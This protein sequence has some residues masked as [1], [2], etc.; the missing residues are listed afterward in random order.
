M[1]KPD[2][3]RKNYRLGNK[4]LKYFLDLEIVERPSFTLEKK[5]KAWYRL[6]HGLPPSTTVIR[7]KMVDDKAVEFLEQGT[8]VF[9]YL[10]TLDT[11]F[12]DLATMTYNEED[13]GMPLNTIH[14]TAKFF[15]W[16]REKC[17]GF[18]IGEGISDSIRCFVQ[19]IIIPTY[20][21]LKEI[22]I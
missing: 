15:K 3:L 5:Q 11:G 21:V 9:C 8:E 22:E 17:K 6:L 1:T 14:D 12:I 20:I 4:R 13:R 19:G 16:H 7:R 2:I 10:T 18:P